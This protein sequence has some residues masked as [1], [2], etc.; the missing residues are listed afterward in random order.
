MNQLAK[1]LSVQP[2]SLPDKNITKA[3]AAGVAIGWLKGLSKTDFRSDGC[4]PQTAVREK[5][6]A[7]FGFSAALTCLL[8]ALN[9]VMQSYTKD[10]QNTITDVQK[11]MIQ[12][13]ELT[14]PGLKKIAPKNISRIPGILR[15]RLIELHDISQNRATPALANSAS[16]T[17]TLVLQAFDSL[18]IKF[19]L[20]IDSIRLTGKSVNLS[21]SVPNIVSHVE[22][23]K[24]IESN[25]NLTIEKWDFTGQS[26]ARKTFNMTLT[27]I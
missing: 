14:H 3:F 6:R 13:Y 24:A 1:N 26:S 5:H 18:P 7:L 27:V 16:M 23:D 19:D 15:S 12:A 22:L 11:R 2:L 10:Y 20:A 9:A 4:P 21:G 25:P 17:L 8:L